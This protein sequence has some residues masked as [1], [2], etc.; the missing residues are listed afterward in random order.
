MASLSVRLSSRLLH[1]FTRG[2]QFARCLGGKKEEANLSVLEM[3]SGFE[4]L[5]GL[6][7]GMVT[8]FKSS[9]LMIFHHPR[10]DWHKKQ[11]MPE[12]RLSSF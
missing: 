8:N 5:D 7:E 1:V 3:Q 10:K 9:Q 2:Q 4:L 12:G 6:R 11:E